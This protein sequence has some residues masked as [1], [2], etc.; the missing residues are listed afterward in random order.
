MGNRKRAKALIGLLLAL[1]M[2]FGPVGELGGAIKAQAA[3][4][5]TLRFHYHRDDGNYDKWSVW[6]WKDK[7]AGSKRAFTSEDA[8]GKVLTVTGISSSTDVKYGFHV[9]IIER[10]N[11]SDV[12]KAKDVENDRFV[13]IKSG[14]TGY[15]DVY[16]DAGKNAF[17]TFSGVSE[18]PFEVLSGSISGENTIDLLFTS[19]ND[20]ALAALPSQLKITD[21]TAS[22]D[23]AISDVKFTDGAKVRVTTTEKLSI[24]H[25]YKIVRMEDGKVQSAVNASVDFNGDFFEENYTYTGDDLGNTYTPVSTTFKVW[26]P[27]ATNVEVLLFADGTT[28]E[29]EKTV[30]MTGGAAENKGVW[31]AVESGDLKDKYYVY[32]VSF[33]NTRR[34]AMDPYAKAGITTNDNPSEN[35][36]YAGQRGM[37]TDLAAAS[38]K[39][40]GSD[41]RINLASPTDA[42]IYETSVRDF[43]SDSDSGI[44]QANQKKYLAFTE[45]GTK[46][47][48]GTAT[49]L[50]YLSQLGITHVQLMPTF[51]F[52]GISEVSG[53]NYNWGYNPVN[54][55]IPEGSFS[56]DPTRGDVRVMEYKQM[57]QALHGEN[58]GVVMDV[59]YNHVNNAGT[60]CYNK[61]VPGY[62]F[63]GSNGSGCG[64]DV[65]SERTMVSKYIVDSVAYWAEEYHLDGF[66][67][68]LVGLLDVNTMNALR[69]KLNKI[70]PD[71]LV[72]G[73]GWSLGTSVT[74]TADLATQSN[75]SK[76]P[77]VGM[78]ND[79]IRD[80][81]GGNNDA[82][83]AGYATG[84]GS[85]RFNDLKNAIA[86]RVWYTNNP[87]QNINYISCHD[88]YTLWDKISKINSGKSLDVKKQMNKLAAAINITSQGIPLFLSGEEF[89]RTKNG[90]HNSY[91]SSDSVNM[92]DWSK[93]DDNAEI[94]DYYKGLIALR[95]AHAGLRMSSAEDIGNNLAFLSTS[96]NVI[97]YTVN[98]GA[99]GEIADKM[100]VAFNPNSVA[101]SITLPAGQWSLLVDGQ[102]AG[103]EVLDKVSGTLS[104]TP[105]SAYVLVQGKADAVSK[106]EIFGASVSLKE[107]SVTYTGQAITPAVTSVTLNGTPLVKDR[108]YKVVYR[109]NLN[110]GTASVVIK[111]T[112]EYTGRIIKTFKIVKRNNNLKISCANVTYGAAPV[113][114]AVTNSGK[115]KVTYSYKKKGS[116]DKTYT[117]T[118]P[119][120]AGE[121][122]VR[123]VTASTAVYNSA[124]STCTF[125]INRKSLA[126]AKVS[127]ISSKKSYTGK[128]VKQSNIK[129]KIGNKTLKSGTDYKVTYSNNKKVGKAKVKITG[130]GNY[131][132]TITKTFQI[133]PAKVSGVAV[134]AGSRRATITWKKAKGAAGYQ[135][136]MA[137]KK[138][139]TY[140]LVKTLTGASKLKYTKTKL[141]RKKTYYFKVRAYKKG[142]KGTYSAVKSVKVK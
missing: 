54:Y 25:S 16:L 136:W 141:T 61:I 117:A 116:S 105:Y 26:A 127:G 57:V 142:Y 130:I 137:T 13:T 35:N 81:I 104:L 128:T 30:S 15:V 60:F 44:S 106:K 132:G 52:T 39:D 131:S 5:V 124:T 119:V 29:I 32:R 34:I 97:A 134:K 79:V 82:N 111:G 98:G 92:L 56:S 70:N 62:F 88:N 83:V 14:T 42:V 18:M 31:E 122:V 49:G 120:K 66:R 68:D 77:G 85:Y 9:A 59:V 72:Y 47:S 22:C 100:L 17:K 27:T 103:A 80:A 90:N 58:I 43:S 96:G 37:V 76:M 140:K 20:A 126:G 78:F 123:G 73:E 12:W 38:P 7:G 118:K 74:K 107:S 3:T 129:V 84:N 1:I 94:V 113:P 115:L 101:K 87:T 6:L 109:N 4:S 46:N 138:K 95:N 89:L 8:Y 19:K 36:Y 99:N 63:R 28:A 23:I 50:D 93:L 11:G 2:A 91:K 40:W 24:G 133:I 75:T 21:L 86:S 10:E 51:D 48:K 65:A 139:G 114:K 112:G 125:K 67:F 135:V 53:K 110:V 69:E 41:A 45:H 108:D 64:N 33:G 102:D 121:Y 55:N 71:I